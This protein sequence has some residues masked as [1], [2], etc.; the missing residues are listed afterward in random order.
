[1]DAMPLPSLHKLTRCRP[2]LSTGAPEEAAEEEEID[3]PTLLT[4][5]ADVQA[6]IWTALAAPAESY[7]SLCSNMSNLAV[8]LG[9]SSDASRD[10]DAFPWE[11][12]CRVLGL[13][14]RVKTRHAPQG[15]S[16]RNCLF[17][18]CAELDDQRRLAA[19][20]AERNGGQRFGG[21]LPDLGQYLPRRLPEDL[22]GLYWYKKL[23]EHWNL[24][25]RR[26]GVAFEHRC[27]EFLLE[28]LTVKAPFLRALVAQRHPTFPASVYV[29]AGIPTHWNPNAF[30]VVDGRWDV[31]ANVQNYSNAMRGF[32]RRFSAAVV[33]RPA[34]RPTDAQLIAWIDA[35]VE[36]GGDL[37]M[38]IYRVGVDAEYDHAPYSRYGWADTV[39]CVAVRYRSVAVTR[40]CLEAGAHPAHSNALLCACVGE[41]WMEHVGRAGL[42]FQG[43]FDPELI[44]VLVRA[45]ATL[46]DDGGYIEVHNGNVSQDP[47]FSHRRQIVQA[48]VLT[49]QL[50]TAQQLLTPEAMRG[51]YAEFPRTREGVFQVTQYDPNKIA[52]LNTRFDW[53]SLVV[54]VLV[55]DELLGVRQQARALAFAS[56]LYEGFRQDVRWV[57]GW[58]S[59]WLAEP[60]AGPADINRDVLAALA[61]L[62]HQNPLLDRWRLFS[63]VVDF[64]VERGYEPLFRGDILHPMLSSLLH[65]DPAHG[66]VTAS[67]ERERLVLFDRMLGLLNGDGL[68]LN[69][70]L[71]NASFT[72]EHLAPLD[73]VLRAGAWRYE[74][75]PKKN[76]LA[77]VRILRSHGAQPADFWDEQREESALFGAVDHCN[78]A[79]LE[80]YLAAGA[81]PD[82]ADKEGYTLL[83]YAQDRAEGVEG[84]ERECSASI[85]ELL[86]AALDETS[87]S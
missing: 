45:G 8:A 41:R 47:Q 7:E 63:R 22:D 25:G 54:W 65:A 48:L 82:V 19:D 6:M 58:E 12:P 73:Y 21:V 55:A 70:G 50:E 42:A 28:H 74:E 53:R 57:R 39:L 77:V 14:E 72:Q 30:G 40:R 24:P 16:W 9:T 76:C 68:N 33:R 69:I 20:R 81:R 59:S 78:A 66:E 29:D 86:E 5:Q 52:K 10:L 32:D 49:G 11:V 71:A 4:L 60:Q 2:A 3:A 51:L 26:Q 38:R 64:V 1:M 18:L 43:D 62:L 56:N 36:W 27:L 75:P 23:F 61:P 17:G 13:R 15:D 84:E 44:S 87:E 83:E 46:L 79:L 31:R 35:L 80:V 37:N 85:V 67:S 34:E